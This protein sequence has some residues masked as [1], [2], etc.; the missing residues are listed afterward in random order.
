MEP[1]SGVAADVARSLLIFAQ[2][3][4]DVGAWWNAWLSVGIHRRQPGGTGGHSAS[5]PYDLAE[6]W[7]MYVLPEVGVLCDPFAGSGAMLQAGLDNGAS[8]VI[9]VEK[10]KKYLTIARKRIEAS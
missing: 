3:L 5:T 2:R 4:D 9:A 7:C 8:S 10:M 1:S 6:W